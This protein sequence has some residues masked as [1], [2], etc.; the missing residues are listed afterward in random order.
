MATLKG[1]SN[2]AAL[3]GTSLAQVINAVTVDRAATPEQFATFFA[4]LA[5]YLGVPSRVVTGF[6]APAAAAATGPLP[7]GD[8]GL[9]NRDAWTWTSC[10]LRA[11]GG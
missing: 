11:W 6:R 10:P 5:R 2:P 8:Y 4:V 1:Q 3:A 9:T 7:A